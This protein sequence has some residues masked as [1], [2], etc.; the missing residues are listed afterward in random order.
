LFSLWTVAY[1]AASD[2]QVRGSISNTLN[3][4]LGVTASMALV[5]AVWDRLLFR[6]SWHLE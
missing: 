3:R 4:H 1:R 5:I 2:L 6:R